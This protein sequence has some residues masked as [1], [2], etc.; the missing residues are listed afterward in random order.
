MV[1][2]TKTYVIQKNMPSDSDEGKVVHMYVIPFRYTD[3]NSTTPRICP[4]RFLAF[5]AAWTATASILAT[6]RLSKA[7]GEAVGPN[8][9]PGLVM[10]VFHVIE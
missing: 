8:F 3:S 5:A 1:F 7:E 9:V 2:L 6:F 10:L 4:G